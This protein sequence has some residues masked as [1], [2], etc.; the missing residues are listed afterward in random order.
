MTIKP[1]RERALLKAIEKKQN[2]VKGVLLPDGMQEKL[3]YYRVIS[4]NSEFDDINSGDIVIINIY[5]GQEIEVD[6]EK[7]LIVFVKDITAIISE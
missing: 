3:T 2:I 4:V 6:N 1:M 5:T 7:F